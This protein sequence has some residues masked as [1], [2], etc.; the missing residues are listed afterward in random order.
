MRIIL[1]LLLLFKTII[2]NAVYGAMLMRV[3]I[4]FQN[5]FIS[6]KRFKIKIIKLILFIYS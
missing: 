3:P 6:K 4:L 5:S 2:Y 1:L